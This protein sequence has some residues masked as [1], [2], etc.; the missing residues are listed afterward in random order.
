[1]PIFLAIVAVIGGLGFWRR[2][3][4][5]EEAQKFSTAARQN[6]SNMRSG[7]KDLLVELGERV[8]AKSTGDEEENNDTEIDRLIGALVQIDA[9]S[10]SDD[11]EPAV[12]ADASL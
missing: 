4:I 7:R 10:G 9:N 8:Y 6:Y 11:K 5:E 3:Q 2:K 12:E 1:M